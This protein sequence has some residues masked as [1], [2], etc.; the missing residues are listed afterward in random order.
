MKKKPEH[1]KHE[2][3]P[4]ADLIPYAN[5]ARTHSPEQITQLAGAIKEFKF[6]NPVLIDP[7]GGIIAGHGRVMAAQKLGMVDVPCIILDGLT[8]AQR[9][10]Y[11]IADN[12][13]ALNS[14]WDTQLLNLEIES[15][16]ELDFNIDLLGFGD[17]ELAGLSPD[18]EPATEDEQGQLDELDPKWID[19]PHCGKEFDARR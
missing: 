8:K 7:D 4:V 3:R 1:Y 6:T 19:C 18:F 10:A 15:L 12:K 17:D 13:L 11:V 16:K 9:K 14:G 2:I 5:N